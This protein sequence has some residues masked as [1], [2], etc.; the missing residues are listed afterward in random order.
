MKA[1]ARTEFIPFAGLLR[2]LPACR[3]ENISVALS[4]EGVSPVTN[5]KDQ[6]RISV[7]ITLKILSLPFIKN[8]SL[9]INRLSITA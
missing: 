1:D 5:A 9:K 6:R 3:K 8:R 7:I 2:R 4:T